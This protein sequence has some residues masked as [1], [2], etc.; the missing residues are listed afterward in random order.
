MTTGRAASRS[1]TL[2]YRHTQPGYASAI[3]LLVGLVGVGCAMAGVFGPTDAPG[4]V[5]PL[6]GGILLAT[7]LTFGALTVQVTGRSLSF[8]F[9][10]GVP[11]RTIE[12]RRVRDVLIVRNPWY[13]GWGIHLTPNGWIYNVSGTWAIELEL[14]DG[15][16]L[17]IGTDEPARLLTA[18]ELGRQAW[19]G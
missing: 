17:R 14:E 5:F 18:I 3:G 16:R 4:W 7:G 11:R 1:L 2:P 15:A 10:L 9:G 8:H 13:Y 19:S 12:L 6:V